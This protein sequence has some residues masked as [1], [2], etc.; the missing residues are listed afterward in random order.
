[1]DPENVVVQSCLPIIN[2]TQYASI[3]LE[4]HCVRTLYIHWR[5]VV[6]P[7]QILRLEV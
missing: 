5:L 7:L 3:K 2:K 4:L 1:M 6:I